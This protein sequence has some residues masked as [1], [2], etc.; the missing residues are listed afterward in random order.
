VAASSCVHAGR[1]RKARGLRYHR[2]RSIF[3]GSNGRRAHVADERT[4]NALIM[5]WAVRLSHA[6]H[7]SRAAAEIG[8][9]QWSEGVEVA[10]GARRCCETRAK[11]SLRSEPRQS[12]SQ[13][14][15]V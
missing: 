3:N 2:A 10:S 9:M 1:E 5:C 6:R 13:A 15:R 4:S 11:W 14:E 12:V 7:E 8:L